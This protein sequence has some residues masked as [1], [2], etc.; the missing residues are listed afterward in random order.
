[1]QGHT[2]NTG[3]TAIGPIPVLQFERPQWAASGPET[4]CADL[5]AAASKADI[6]R[7]IK[8]GPYGAAG[9]L[10]QAILPSDYLWLVSISEHGAFL[11]YRFPEGK[12]R[13]LWTLQFD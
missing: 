10:S 6:P 11:W 7:A 2:T 4:D 1:M 12:M 3:Q 9:P 5:V 8:G 13:G